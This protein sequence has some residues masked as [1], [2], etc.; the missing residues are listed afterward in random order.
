MMGLYSL[1]ARPHVFT[2]AG[3]FRE[4]ASG[5]LQHADTCRGTRHQHSKFF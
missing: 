5:S 4:M 2:L 1:R 3:S